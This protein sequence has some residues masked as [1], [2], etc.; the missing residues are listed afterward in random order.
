MRA[1][2]VSRGTLPLAALVILG[3]SLDMR[4]EMRRDGGS[5][6]VARTWTREHRARELTDGRC[7]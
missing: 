3:A 4:I 1:A 6:A 7:Q 2:A 5:W